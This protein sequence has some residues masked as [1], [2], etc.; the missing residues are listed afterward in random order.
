MPVQVRETAPVFSDVDF[1]CERVA[2]GL[3]GEPLN[4]ISALAF[5]LVGVWAFSRASFVEDRFAAGALVL[6]GCASALQHGFAVSITFWG[7]WAANLLYFIALV[8]LLLRRFLVESRFVS[9]FGAC[10]IMVWLYWLLGQGHVRAVLGIFA[11]IFA[12]LA[13]TLIVLSLCTRGAVLVSRGLALSALLIIAGFPFRV[14]DGVFCSSWAIG[15]HG[16]WHL[17]NA[18]SAA[19]LLSALNAYGKRQEQ[20]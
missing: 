13:A 14:L 7:D 19:V 9:V 20:T 18:A 15:T 12:I 16:I 4:M 1:Y 6:V 17:F 8:T 5:C 11:D 2:P 3:G 10:I